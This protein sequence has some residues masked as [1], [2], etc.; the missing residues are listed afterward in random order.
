MD[1]FSDAMTWIS[2]NEAAL[3]GLAAMIVVAGVIF[4]P[5]GVG[6]RRM[7]SGRADSDP[8]PA[9]SPAT[10]AVEPPL[11]ETEVRSEIAAPDVAAT[12]ATADRPSIAVL[13]FDNMS[14]DQEQEFL[15]DGMTEDIITGLSSNRYLHVVSRNSTFAYKGA[16]PDIRA[17]GRDLGV[18][19][20]LEGSIRRVGDRIR[21]TAQ[22]IESE[23][24]A[25][26]WAEKFDRPYA[27]IFD[28]Q[29]EL[30][31][32]ITGALNAQLSSA[33]RERARRAQ[34]ANLDAWELL[35][36]GLSRLFLDS[37]T[38]DGT[39]R[40]LVNLRASLELDPDYTYAR[41]A[42]A[43]IL[44][45][46]AI[47]GHSDDPFGALTEGNE[48]LKRAL[49]AAGDDPLTLFYIGAAYI[50]SGR[51][52]LG[53]RTLE[54][55]LVYSPDQ[56]DVYM[57]LGMAHGYLGRFEQAHA[58]FDRAEELASTGGMSA[59]Y[60]WYRSQVLAFEE[61]YEEAVELVRNH[62]EKAPRYATARIEL[63]LDLA[64]MGRMDEARACIERA[65]QNDPRI[66]L[67]GLALIVG[68]HPDSQLAAERVALLREYW[69]GS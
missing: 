40:I 16:S 68:A 29:D 67:E 62:L 18:R 35:Q 3:S 20:V 53:I 5:V 55:S 46:S 37:P 65:V 48:H 52:E 15:A 34:P 11:P 54:R 50:Y 17:V 31:A 28:L 41:A 33:E 22:L 51:H 57:H 14:S 30:I 69:P 10:R 45:S 61:R 26:L 21:T 36:R 24:G 63:G 58:H 9:S 13:P 27:S 23:S 7:F 19:Y 1:F 49:E 59:A 66:N 42:L 56:P 38:F 47:N 4:T 12:A 64:A 8:S 39:Q 2:E 6:L 60:G 44:F 32:N 43:W 25:H